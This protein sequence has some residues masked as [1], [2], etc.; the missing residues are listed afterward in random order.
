MTGLLHILELQLSVLSPLLSSLAP[1]KSVISCSKKGRKYFCGMVCGK[2][3]VTDMEV[4]SV[5]FRK[6][7]PTSSVSV[8]IC[9]CLSAVPA[10][11]SIS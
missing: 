4:K 10:P 8:C 6:R 3:Y 9:Q 11:N 5:G 2:E 1:I 7:M